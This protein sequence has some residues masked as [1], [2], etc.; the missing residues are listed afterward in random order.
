MIAFFTSYVFGL[1]MVK[2][3]LLRLLTGQLI[4]LSFFPPVVQRI[5][6]FLPFSSM[7]YTPVMI[8]LDKYAPL[9]LVFVLLRQVIWIILLY[10]IGSLI[11]K[12]VVKRL[13]VLGG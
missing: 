2:E 8:Y 10:V 5:F 4:P 13:V 3:A 7:I 1:L 11:W 9:E 6:D 12:Q